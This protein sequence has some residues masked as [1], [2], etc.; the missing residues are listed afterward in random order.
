M[1]SHND[2]QESQFYEKHRDWLDEWMQQIKEYP[3]SFQKFEWNCQE[4]NPQDE[5][6]N[7]SK[8]MIQTRPSGVRIKRPTTAPSLVAMAS[9][10]IPIVG[11]EDRYMTLDECKKLQSFDEN[12][13]LPESPGKA[14]SALGNAV[15]VEVAHRVAKSLL[16]L[17]SA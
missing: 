5:D 11:W 17:E 15:N 8:Y 1:E 2:S 6:R 13:N 16:T 3:S 9:T 4:R 14:Y 10:Q 7:I 12:F